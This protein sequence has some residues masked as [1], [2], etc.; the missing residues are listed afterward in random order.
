MGD[1]GD[2]LTRAEQA[3]LEFAYAG[4]FQQLAGLDAVTQA[5]RGGH[6]R[7]LAAVGASGHDAGAGERDM[8][9]ADDAAGEHEV[10]DIAAVHRAPRDLID[11]LGVPLG[12]AGLRAVNAIHRVQ[13]DRP[14]AE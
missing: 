2:E 5:D 7:R 14:T 10:G 3:A 12:A 13:I 4:R 9:G 11:S 6:S 8:G 1:A